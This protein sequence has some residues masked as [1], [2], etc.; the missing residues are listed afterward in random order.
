MRDR[1]SLRQT[2]MLAALFEPTVPARKLQHTHVLERSAVLGSARLGL[3]R[4]GSAWLGLARLGSAW[5]GCCLYVRR[6]YVFYD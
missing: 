4:F 5:L 6:N 3:A 2:K 1:P